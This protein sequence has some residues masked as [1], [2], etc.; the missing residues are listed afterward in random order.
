MTAGQ[1]SRW[2][3]ERQPFTPVVN[4]WL[5]EIACDNIVRTLRTNWSQVATRYDAA[6]P[7]GERRSLGGVRKLFLLA[8]SARL[9]D[10]R[11]DLLVTRRR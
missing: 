5:A 3:A 11:F 7:L 2:P 9:T 8:I 4:M 6:P 10:R 1:C